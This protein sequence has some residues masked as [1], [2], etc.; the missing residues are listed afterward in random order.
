[1][2]NSMS[3]TIDNGR[4]ASASLGHDRARHVRILLVEDS[5]SDVAMTRA[6]LERG[7]RRERSQPS[8]PTASRR[9]RSSAGKASTPAS[10]ARISFSWI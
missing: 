4:A 10:I 8:S 5:P 9:S 1:M 7:P 3:S 6:A 2:S